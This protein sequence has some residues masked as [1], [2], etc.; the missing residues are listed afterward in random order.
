TEFNP[1]DSVVPLTKRDL[2]Q[3]DN[4]E[5]DVTTTTGTQK[6]SQRQSLYTGRFTLGQAGDYCMM[7]DLGDMDN[8]HWVVIDGV[9]CIDESNLWLPP[10]AGKMVRLSAGEHTVQVVCKAGNV[11]R[12]SWRAAGNTTTFRSPNARRLDY[13]VFAGRD[14]DEVIESYRSLSGQVPM[15]PLWAYGFWQCRER[16]TSG[17]H[18]VE[19]VAEFR[20][21]KLP[22]D[23]IVQDWQY[24][25]KNGWGVP[26]FDE[27][28]YPD[29]RGFIGRLHDMHAHF[30]I[31]VWENLDRKSGVAKPYVA[32]GLYI[33]NSPW[34]DIFNP[35]AR[36]THWQALNENLFRL[37]VDGWW[38]D[39]TEPENDAL[40]GKQTF[41]GS[42]D[43]YRLVYPLFVSRAVYEGQRAAD[44][45]K[46]VCILTRSAF[47]GQQRYGTINWSGDIGSTWDAYRRQIVAGL[48]YTMTGLPY[49]TT[50]IGGFFRPGR[51]QYTDPGYRELLTRWF[52]WGALN[53]V[54]RV[55]GYQTETEPWKYGD[56]V[57]N[58]M[59]AM[60]DLRYRLLPYIYG[61]AWEVSRHGS[62]IMRPLAMDFGGDTTAMGQRY[63][64]MFGRS[65]LAAPVT[66]PGAD[67]RVV[68]L[69]GGASWFDFWTGKRYTGGGSVKV[70]AP[71]SRMPLLVRAG[72][73][74]PM[75]PVIQSTAEDK[76]DSLEIRIYTGADGQFT[77]YSDEGDGYGYEQGQY[78]TIALKWDDRRKELSIGA[79]SGKYKGVPESRVF[80]VVRVN[81]P[82]KTVIYRGKAMTVRLPG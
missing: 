22:M 20:K 63:E 7:L 47:A 24:W 41:L 78:Q 61:N 68:Y 27:E 31:S 82:E 65:F 28:H 62:T 10:A 43:F 69:P 42:G 3:G 45:S 36:T 15:L 1:A 57:M 40:K 17:Q 14:A 13:V 11:P 52:Q 37:G 51:G 54:F 18:L 53:P 66:E 6:L 73:V 46:R 76:G 67:S 33:P 48:G 2:A 81:G 12:L 50:D 64:Y 34:V 9:S 26:R 38:M 21:R 79:A 74:V 19:T 25:G 35:E 4:R 29:P 71:L 44:P 30:V 59:R 70:D 75:G 77:L 16:Y 80:R 39:A 58:D 55:H 8:R 60:L 72:S 5:A 32:K 23:A 49:W 56:T